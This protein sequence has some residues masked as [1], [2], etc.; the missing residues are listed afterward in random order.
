MEDF[1]APHTLG[2]DAI[3]LLSAGFDGAYPSLGHQPKTYTV[4]EKNL[5]SQQLHTRR[6][7]LLVPLTGVTPWLPCFKAFC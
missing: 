6:M 2:T 3:S 1:L 7:S 4:S 5:A